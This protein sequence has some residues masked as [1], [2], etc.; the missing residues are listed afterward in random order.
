[1]ERRVIVVREPRMLAPEPVVGL[2]RRR[3]GEEGVEHAHQHEERNQRLEEPQVRHRRGGD[4]V[5]RGH[6]V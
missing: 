5:M 3:A 1:M 6:G 2:V 4:G